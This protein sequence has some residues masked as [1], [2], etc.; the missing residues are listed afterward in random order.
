MQIEWDGA[1]HFGLILFCGECN[2]GAKQGH[3]GVNYLREGWGV[4]C[5]LIKTVG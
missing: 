5:E 4:D 1:V 2:N 3:A